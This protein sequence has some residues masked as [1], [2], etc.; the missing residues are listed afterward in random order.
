M[1]DEL[2]R[3]RQASHGLTGAEALSAMGRAHV[4]MIT[5]DA[6]RRPSDPAVD[7]DADDRRPHCRRLSDKLPGPRINRSRF[8]AAG[9]RTRPTHPDRV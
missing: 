7:R 1:E 3:F 8:D 9:G 4:E 5:T 2:E 6:R